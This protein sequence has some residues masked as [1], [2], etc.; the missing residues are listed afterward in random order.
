M[1]SDTAS[2]PADVAAMA[3]ASVTYTTVLSTNMNICWL[4]LASIKASGMTTSER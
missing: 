4:A 2:S 1:S 3:N